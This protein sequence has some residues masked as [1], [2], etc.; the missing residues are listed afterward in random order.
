M[1]WRRRRRTATPKT[2][3]SE[4]FLG[5]DAR[6]R[7]RDHIHSYM[8]RAGWRCLFFRHCGAQ[9]AREYMWHGCGVQRALMRGTRRENTIVTSFMCSCLAACASSVP[10]GALRIIAGSRLARCST[11]SRLD[12]CAPIRSQ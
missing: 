1:R 12:G 7:T 3:R 11:E 10:L 9:R 4:R 2:R 5:H 6:R 8:W